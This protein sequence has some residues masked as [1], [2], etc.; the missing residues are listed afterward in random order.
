MV[1]NTKLQ[2]IMLVGIPAAGK[3]TYIRNSNLL[4]YV[5]ISSDNII[6]REATKLGKT[7]TEVFK[8]VI[9][10]V[11]R[12][13]NRDFLDAINNGKNIIW[14][15]TNLVASKRTGI[16]S[17]LPFNYYKKAVFFNVDLTLAKDRAIARGK[18]TGKHIP[19]RV[20]DD[21]HSRLEVPTESEGFD[22]IEL[23]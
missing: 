7:Y 22:E 8:D 15:H 17:R 6:E 21:M 10:D 16:L 11:Q 3:S 18:A 2:F 14:D 5:I 13:K 19:S 20:L 1:D 4:D 23:M 12:E 9:G